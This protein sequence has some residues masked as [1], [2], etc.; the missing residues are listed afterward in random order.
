MT[1]LVEERRAYVIDEEGKCGGLEGFKIISTVP[2]N[3]PKTIPAEQF[4]LHQKKGEIYTYHTKSRTYVDNTT[5][6]RE[7]QGSRTIIA[8]SVQGPMKTSL[9][10]VNQQEFRGQQLVMTNQGHGKHSSH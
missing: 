8:V 10:M 5:C 2:N 4:A 9:S 7:Q 3:Y 6:I 1:D